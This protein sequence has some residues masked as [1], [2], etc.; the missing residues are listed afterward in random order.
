MIDK[1]RVFQSA[2]NWMLNRGWKRLGAKRKQFNQSLFEHTLVE[3]DVALQLL[4]ILKQPCHFDL[5]TEE[6]QILVVSLIA[7]DVGKERP[8]WQDYLLGRRDF[9]SDVDPELTSI[10]VVDLCSAFGF[11]GLHSKVMAVMENCVNLHMR[12]ERR[13]SNIVLAMF[14]GMDR[15]YTLANLVYHIDNICSAKGVFE[16]RAA[17]ERSILAKHLKVAYHQVIIRGVSTTALHRAALESYQEA[18]WTPLLHFSD[19]TL[20]V[21]SAATP[22]KEPMPG[23]IESRLAEVLDE[24]IGREVAPLVVGKDER[25]NFLP[26]PE[27][28]DCRELKFYLQEASKRA[29]PRSFIKKPHGYRQEVVRKYLAIC[30][31]LTQNLDESVVDLH[32]RRISLARP[33]MAV[34]RF[35]KYAMGSNLI[36][37]Q[38]VSMVEQEYDAVFGQGAWNDLRSM[39]TIMPAPDM[40]KRVDRFWRLPG[41]RFG[42]NINSIEELAPDKRVKLL[43]DVL[44]DIANKVYSSIPNPPTRATLAR[45]MA[46]SFVRDLVSPAAQVDLA[47]TARQ[48][49]EFYAVSKPFAGKQTKKARYIC[50]VCNVQFEEGVKAKADFIDNPESHTNRGIAHGPFGYITLC[51]SCYYERILR[52]LLLGERAAELIIIFPHMNIGP[53]AGELLVR[54]AEA[55]YNRAYALMVGDTDDPDRRLSLA[56]TSYI[57]E[58]MIQQDLYRLAPEEFVDLLTYRSSEENRRKNRRELEKKL[59]EQY[60]DD[61][62]AANDEWGTDFKTWAE[63]TEAVYANQVADPMARHIRAEVYRLYPQMRLVCQTPHMIILPVGYSIKL[64]DDSEVNAALRRTFVAL[65][66]GLNLDASVAIVRDSDQID[67]QGGEGVAFVPPVATAREL[68]GSNWVPINEAERWLKALGIASILASIGQYSARSGLF[69]VLTAPTAGHV[70]RRIEQKKAIEKQPLTYRDINYIR[71]FAEVM[72]R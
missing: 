34:F 52:Q 57:A 31:N 11:T 58:Q 10:A 7:H 64:N 9:V 14:K 38:G 48:Q 8:E 32:S 17:F 67:F 39:S 65:L 66:L 41:K 4:P 22:V 53:G 50:P 47:E 13:D 33:E 36:G 20:Y 28:F 68:I 30:G 69:E 54:K 19:A 24:A 1:G 70:L 26:K 40:A 15:W 60:E 59:R 25:Q 23:K 44:D 21:C 43:I 63:A 71:I 51:R 55:L 6:E 62:E 3:L 12:H 72:Q 49:M 29:N 45:A 61:L 5:T 2:V 16:A 27:L 56:F 46:A 35:F 37:A 42:L 18:G